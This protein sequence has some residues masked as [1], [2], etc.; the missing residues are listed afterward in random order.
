MPIISYLNES[1]PSGSAK[2]IANEALVTIASEAKKENIDL[3]QLSTLTLAAFVL[4]I[5]P[6]IERII[7][8]KGRNALTSYVTAQITSLNVAKQTLLNIMDNINTD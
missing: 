5:Q 7:A 3:D 6:T 1:L 8:E 4:S 2:K